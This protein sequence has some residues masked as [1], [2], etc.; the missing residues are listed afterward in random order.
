M[1]DI[2][3]F[4]LIGAAGGRYMFGTPEC[5]VRLARTPTGLRGAPFEAAYQQHSRQAGETFKSRRFK[6]GTV[7]LEV[8]IGRRGH[9]GAQARRIEEQWH[10][11][12]G[13]TETTC[14]FVVVSSES[15]YRWRDLRLQSPLEPA[16]WGKPGLIGQNAEQVALASDDAM[17]THPPMTRLFDRTQFSGAQI[18]NDGDQPAWLTWTLGGETS[19]WSIGVDGETIPLPGTGEGEV[20][21]IYTDPEFPTI[22]NQDGDDLYELPSMSDKVFYKP[23][24][25][26]GPLAAPTPLTIN[27]SSPG[28]DAQV[29]VEWQPR[30][31]AAW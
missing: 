29:L 12:L 7:G 3:R 16:D 1:S 4:G 22:T 31:R 17:W 6:R 25:P 27:A 8:F 13:N 19:G 18:V 30:S 24:P 11:D 2:L 21:K 28:E 26:G 10:A 5:P 23:L 15:G 9:T 14:R 20:I